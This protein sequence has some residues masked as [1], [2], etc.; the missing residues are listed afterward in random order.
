MCVCVCIIPYVSLIFFCLE[1]CTFTSCEVTLA[2]F[3]VKWD[4][5]A[6]DYPHPCTTESVIK[7]ALI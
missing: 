2:P 4:F 1:R 5:H 7:S 6:L 3:F